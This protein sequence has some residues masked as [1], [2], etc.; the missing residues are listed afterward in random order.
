MMEHWY[1]LLPLILLMAA[2]VSLLAFDDWRLMLAGVAV[3]YFGAFL[4]IVQ[5]APAGIALIKLVTGLMASALLFVSFKDQKSEQP[6][7]AWSSLIFKVTALALVWLVMM[8]VAGSFQQIFPLNYET[9]SGA[10]I[11]LTG[12]LLVLGTTK[13]P[14]K[15]TMG[16][17]VLYSGFDILYTPLESSILI[18]GL[19]SLITMLIA[20]VGMYISTRHESEY[21]E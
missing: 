5:A 16:I 12:G 2:G 4:L 20:L 6:A 13:E 15:V 9:I 19:L 11:A 1:N 10:L 3:T 7:L 18:N 17:L 21:E 14:A 8:L